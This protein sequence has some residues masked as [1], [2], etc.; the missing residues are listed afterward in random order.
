MVVCMGLCN[1]KI[2]ALGGIFLYSLLMQHAVDSIEKRDSKKPPISCTYSLNEP[3]VRVVMASGPGS[4]T[5]HRK[6]SRQERYSAYDLDRAD[7]TARSIGID[8][9]DRYVYNSMSYTNASKDFFSKLDD[10]KTR[11][12]DD[13]ITIMVADG[14]GC[15]QDI[16]L[17]RPKDKG[18]D[19]TIENLGY[20][21]KNI[22]G[23]KIAV[24]QSCNA[25]NFA[26][27]VVDRYNPEKT[28]MIAG[29]PGNGGNGEACFM[30][31]TDDDFIPSVFNY[32]KAYEGNPTKAWFFGSQGARWNNESN[33]WF[34]YASEPELC[35]LSIEP[36]KI[37]EK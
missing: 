15:G 16:A 22:S 20:Y 7:E 31:G 10:I 24:L 5:L 4:D 36:N 18:A 19:L 9:V 30:G 35:K 6:R 37:K 17:K 32:L 23:Y 29:T 26:R 14:H 27:E 13:D 3:V 28:I 21:L 25:G 2:L 33:N 12:S 8:D 1:Y 34:Y 11:A